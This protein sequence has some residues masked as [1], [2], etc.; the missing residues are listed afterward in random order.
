MKPELISSLS[1]NHD[2]HV[3]P[4]LAQQTFMLSYFTPYSSDRQGQIGHFG[5]HLTLLVK[6]MDDNAK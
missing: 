2:I 5:G 4:Y 3:F 1:H 6:E